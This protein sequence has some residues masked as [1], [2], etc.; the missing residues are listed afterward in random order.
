MYKPSVSINQM[1]ILVKSGVAQ[2][3]IFEKENFPYFEAYLRGNEDLHQLLKT[4]MKLVAIHMPH[5][6]EYQGQQWPVDFTNTGIGGEM[7]FKKL[8]EIIDFSEQ[9]DV[10]YVVVHLGFFNTFTEDRW[11]VLDRVGKKFKALEN[12]SV[13][14]KVKICLEN[15]PCW[16][17][18]CFE[19]EP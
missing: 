10:A 8:K 3:P 9:H 13:N 1:K 7:S 5:S 11:K 15:V 6:V 18:I 16:V 2:L 17:N 14:K 4:N 12:N 19:N